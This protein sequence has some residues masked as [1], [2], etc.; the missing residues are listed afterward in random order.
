MTDTYTPDIEVGPHDDKISAIYH[1]HS[2]DD[3]GG[4]EM[5]IA[6]QNEKGEVYRSFTVEGM[7]NYM[8]TATKLWGLGL[9]D[10]HRDK[11]RASPDSLFAHYKS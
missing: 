8:G 4:N 10:L 5:T 6:I 11:I 9:I 3:F 7:S 1:E 2:G